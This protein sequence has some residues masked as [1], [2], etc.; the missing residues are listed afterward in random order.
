MDVDV[1]MDLFFVKRVVL[2]GTDL[3]G[4]TWPKLPQTVE[5]RLS[6]ANSRVAG[7]ELSMLLTN[8]NQ[9]LVIAVNSTH[10]DIVHRMDA[11]HKRFG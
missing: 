10:D 8:E 6:E 11:G 7:L 1:G 5:I 3:V 2:G 9:E 4:D